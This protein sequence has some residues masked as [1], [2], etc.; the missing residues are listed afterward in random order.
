MK[1]SISQKELN[2]LLKA[3]FGAESKIHEGELVVSAMMGTV[4]FRV[5]VAK[6]PTPLN[7]PVDFDISMSL[8]VKMF[9]GRIQQELKERKLDKVISVTPTKLSVDLSSFNGNMFIDWLK[10]KTLKRLEFENGEI[11]I[12]V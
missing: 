6:V 8:A 10:V 2:E 11:S 7:H 3:K 4:K 5:K 9:L 1:F 12:E